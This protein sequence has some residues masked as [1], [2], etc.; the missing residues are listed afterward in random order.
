MEKK[1]VISNLFIYPIKSCA[2]I[3]VD[4][5]YVTKYGLAHYEN[6]NLIDRKW[7]IID[8]NNNFIT[9]RKVPKMALIKPRVENDCLILSAPNMSDLRVPIEIEDKSI[10][11]NC[12]CWSSYLD[13]YSY[14]NQISSW[15]SE[16]FEMPNVDLVVFDISFKN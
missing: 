15:L 8:E 13:S 16:Y 4:K 1:G 10:I 12:R 5:A 2:G 14:G 9:Q 6:P 11:K 3:Q 7:M